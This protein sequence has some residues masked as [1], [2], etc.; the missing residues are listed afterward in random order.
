[1]FV[2]ELCDKII[3]RVKNMLEL[4]IV[5]HGETDNNKKGTYLGWTDV[6]L[7]E[8]GIAQA[9]EAKEKLAGLKIDRFYSSPLSRAKMTA[10]IINENFNL[11]IIFADELKERN[12]GVWDDLKYEEIVRGYPGEHRLWRDDWQNYQIKDGESAQQSYERITNF[13]NGLINKNKEGTY[14]IVTHYGCI[15]KIIA[16]LLGLGLEGLWHFKIDN[17]GISR[18]EI[19]DGFPVLT[20]LN[21]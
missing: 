19:R 5:R 13:V 2:A 3:Q 7:N 12:F 17:C 14:L 21:G 20:E 11:D 15:R 10:E 9:K 16:N 4:I 1:V 8:N 18:I 6:A